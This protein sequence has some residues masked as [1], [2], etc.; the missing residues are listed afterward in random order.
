MDGCQKP[1]MVFDR[2]KELGMNKVAVTNHGN[3]INMPYIIEQGAKK[4]VQV[5]PG[6]ELYVCWDHSALIK[7]VEHK[8][9]Y[10]MVVLAMN[11]TG[12]K[13][14]LQLTSKGYLIGKYHKPRVDREMLE[15]HS[16]GLIV[17]T[18]C[19]N[20][21]LAN[22]IGKGGK[23]AADLSNDIKWLKEVF[24]DRVYL[25]IQRHPNLPEMDAANEGLIELSMI[26]DL[27]VVATCDA[28]YSRKEHFN[29]W[30]SMMLLQTQFRFGHDL[31]N[32]YYIKGHDEMAELFKDF[33]EAIS[34]TARIAERCEP[35]TFDKSI[36]YPPFDTAGMGPDAYLRKLCKEGLDRRIA[37]GQIPA[38]KRKDY[39]ERYDYECKILAEKNFS[40]YILI[41]ADFIVWAKDKGIRVGP[42]RGSGAG[43]LA[44]YLTR[45]TEVDPLYPGW[46]LIFERFINPERD[47]F[48]DIDTDFDDLRRGEVIDYVINKYG[49][50]HVCRILTI[51]GIAAKGAVREICRRYEVPP[52]ETNLFSKMIPGPIRGRATKLEDAPKLSPEFKAKIESDPKFKMIYETA[53]IIEGMAKSTATHA[54]GIII[55]DH[56]K[57]WE[58][59]ALMLDKNGKTTSADDMKVMEMLGFIKMD[60]LGLKTESIIA[61]ILARIYKNHGIKIDIDCIDLNDQSVY[62]D[63]LIK[64]LLAG[65]FQLGGSSGF[66]QVTTLFAPHNI[67]EISD[68]NAVYRPGPLD[69]GFVEYYAENKARAL[70][71]QPIQY[72]M[73]VDNPERQKDIEDIL[74][75]TYGTCLYQEQ[76]QFIAQRVAGYT[77]G[78][79]D[80]LRRAIG[81]KKPEE[82]EIQKKVFVDGCMKNN[83]S[84]QSAVELFTQIEK[85]ADYCFNKSHSIAYSLITYRTAWL[86]KHY[87]A[88]FYAAN[89]TSVADNRNKTIQFLSSCREE[90]IKILPPSIQSSMLDYTTTDEGIRFGLNAVKGIGGSVI[91]P[92]IEERF[93]NG[94]FTSYFNFLTRVQGKGVDRASII[95]LIESG[96]MS[97]L[98]E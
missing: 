84:K 41:V 5:I 16:E 87:P 24:D 14:L 43:C 89:L 22:Q 59:V 30:Q 76:I 39:E 70:R 33:P 83:I 56:K 23:C 34:E 54:A 69:N 91:N 36:K 12:Y 74:K 7:D 26:H 25:E 21:T 88:E 72:M 46:D 45:I 61:D 35:I 94:K 42:G 75:G 40:T 80:L 58:H 92:I 96:A 9:V 50:D 37:A 86:K 44:A 17:L 52:S 57:L 82:M 60:F 2:V 77:L 67:A 10:H 66:K 93:A 6:C 65:V 63:I 32:D 31:E 85:F 15:Q 64:G 29:A 18:A 95:A 8:K 97:E 73:T 90:G 11:N 1:S 62:K 78:G 27:P 20:G 98:L 79:A 49:D 68:I 48:P 38:H 51:M 81:K 55:S 3:V 13:N 28:H 4:G 71:G 19:L 53:L 47:S